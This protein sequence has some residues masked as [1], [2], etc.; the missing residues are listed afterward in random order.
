VLIDGRGDDRSGVQRR[1]DQGGGGGDAPVG[2]VYPRVAGRAGASRGGAAGCDARGRGGWDAVLRS[3]DEVAAN[4]TFLFLAGHETTTNLIGNGLYALLRHPDQL[5]KLR[6][7]PGLVENAIE[8]LLRFDSPVQI[9]SRVA[10]EAIEI[11]GV[12]PEPAPR[13]GRGSAHGR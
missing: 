8:E 9:A 1:A 4:A 2:C 13:P 5:A 12:T 10:L 7:E 3:E 11:E 6:A